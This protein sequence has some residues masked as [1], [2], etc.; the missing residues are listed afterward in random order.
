[1]YKNR[2]EHITFTNVYS[3]GDIIYSGRGLS[4]VKCMYT[5][6]KYCWDRTIAFGKSKT[7]CIFKDFPIIPTPFIKVHIQQGFIN[8]EFG[9][10][11]IHHIRVSAHS[12]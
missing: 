12:N 1:M 11:E 9:K 7:H 3:L 6:V 8:K 2:L 10:D 5:K 4:G